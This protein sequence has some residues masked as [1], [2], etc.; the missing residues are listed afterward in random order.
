MNKYYYSIGEVGN[1]LGVK[2]HVI[3]YWET[4]FPQ[5]KPKKRSGHNRRYTTEDIQILKNIKDMLY[6]QKFTIEGAKKKLTANQK[7]ERSEQPEFNF[8]DDLQAKK[9]Y[10]KDALLDM[11]NSAD[12]LSD[13]IRKVLKE[14]MNEKKL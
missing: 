13:S 7:A 8:A 5:L 4:Q 1:L 10:I 6:N 11:K 14:V 3:R 2:T 12:T 9:K